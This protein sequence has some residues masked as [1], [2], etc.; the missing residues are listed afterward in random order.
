[1]CMHLSVFVRTCVR[2]YMDTYVHL[3]IRVY[4][5]IYR[6]TYIHTYIHTY[7]H[8]YI[9][10]KKCHIHSTHHIKKLKSLTTNWNSTKISIWICTT[11]YQ[12]IWVSRFGRFRRGKF[13][14]WKLSWDL[15]N[16]TILSWACA[17]KSNVTRMSSYECGPHEGVM[18]SMQ[19][20]L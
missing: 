18:T 12:G 11:R 20:S 19:G 9:H 13:F 16:V 17:R 14:Q 8:T 5:H 15:N 6:H 1:M 3:F 4:T 10:A 2:A 7:L